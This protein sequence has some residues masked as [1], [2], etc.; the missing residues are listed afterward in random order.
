VHVSLN[1][2]TGECSALFTLDSDVVAGEVSVVGSFNGWTAGVDTLVLQDDGTLSATVVVAADQ[3]VHFRYLAEGGMW[4]DDPDADEITP[5]G[6]VIHLA[7]PTA[8]TDRDI[9]SGDDHTPAGLRPEQPVGGADARAQAVAADSETRVREQ[10]HDAA[11]AS[12]HT[13]PRSSAQATNPL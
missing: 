13:G 4:F 1:D 5:T 6:S 7:Q 8:T 2:T 10:A 11:G 3:D 12:P 9:E